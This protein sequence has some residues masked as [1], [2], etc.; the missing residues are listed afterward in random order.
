VPRKPT[1]ALTWARS[2]H[3]DGGREWGGLCLMFVRSCF[4][5]DSHYGSAAAAW[6]G[7]QHKHRESDGRKV[8][9]GV[10]Y[11]WTGGSQGFGHV[12]ISAGGGMC[13]SND[14]TVSG[15]ISL[16]PINDITARWRQTPQ[17]WTEDINRVRVWAPPHP[18]QVDF[19][20]LV[21]AFGKDPARPGDEGTD[22]ARTDVRRFERALSTKGYLDA[23]YID[24][25]YGTMTVDGMSR[26]QRQHGMEGNGEPTLESVKAVGRGRFRVQV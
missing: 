16:V 9:R 24:G 18:P 11:F 4:G 6:E 17:G 15:G 7:A 26:F 8:P 25:S 20:D 23:R 2:Q 10:P 21:R 5:V 19:S 3:Q 12:V 1:E 13:W 22:R 14:A